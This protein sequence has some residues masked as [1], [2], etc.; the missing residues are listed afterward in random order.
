MHL[1]LHL[2]YTDNWQLFW[3]LLLCV[4][5]QLSWLHAGVSRTETVFG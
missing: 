5:A 4:I 1:W 3:Q 2:E